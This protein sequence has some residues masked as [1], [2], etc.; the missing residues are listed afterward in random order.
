MIA[1]KLENY[2]LSSSF[3]IDLSLRHFVAEDH[4]VPYNWIRQK[5]CYQM[6]YFINLFLV[7]CSKVILNPL[8]RETGSLQAISG[9]D[10]YTMILFL[11]SLEE[12]YHSTVCEYISRSFICTFIFK[13]VRTSEKLSTFTRVAIGLPIALYKVT[14]HV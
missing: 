7:K 5:K 14:F 8:W 9:L 1:F 10:A 3:I 2:N 11:W 4:F 6:S 12:K 13:E